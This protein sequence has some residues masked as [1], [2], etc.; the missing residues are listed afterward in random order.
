MGGCMVTIKSVKP[1]D[2]YKLYLTFSDGKQGI[3]NALPYLDLG[4]FKELKNPILFKSVRVADATIEWAN[5]ADLCPDCVYL[6]TEY[7]N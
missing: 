7:V 3:F 2:G 1:Q 5:G 4:I 6:E